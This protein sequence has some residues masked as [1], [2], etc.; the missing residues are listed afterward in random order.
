MSNYS[1]VDAEEL[2]GLFK[3]LSNPHRLKIFIGLAR[4]CRP[5]QACAPNMRAC[6][7]E[8]GDGL[9]LAP[10]TISH[11]LKE[12]RQAGLIHMKRAGQHVECW[13]DPEAL[14]RLSEFFRFAGSDETAFAAFAGA[15]DRAIGEKR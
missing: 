3:A 1:N 14:A 6:V 10:S 13:A 9:G 15:Q 4:C 11:H 8:L 12:L 5:G 2:A 7:G